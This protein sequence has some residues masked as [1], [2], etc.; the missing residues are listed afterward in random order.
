VTLF[1]LTRIYHNCFSLSLDININKA[2]FRLISAVL[3]LF[4]N[5]LL[6]CNVALSII[7]N[8]LKLSVWTVK[9][10]HLLK[11]MYCLKQQT[12]L[13]NLLL[14]KR[15]WT[16]I[17]NY[18]LFKCKNVHFYGYG[19]L[20]LYSLMSYIWK[21]GMVCMPLALVSPCYPVLLKYT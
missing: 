2:G 1:V 18:V 3:S 13:Q 15:R 21:R 5:I 12:C 20:Y 9:K 17:W 19:S 7:H 6:L 8:T 10:V 4:I 16:Y 11:Y 14:V